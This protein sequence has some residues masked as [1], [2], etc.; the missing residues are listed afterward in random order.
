ME[1]LRYVKINIATELYSRA[2]NLRVFNTWLDNVL[3]YFG[4]YLLMGPTR[5]QTWLNTLPAALSGD[6]KLWYHTTRELQDPPLTFVNW[7]LALHVEF[8]TRRAASTAFKEYNSCEYAPEKG[9][10]AF[11]HRLITLNALLSEPHDE[12]TLSQQLLQKVPISYINYAIKFRDCTPG[13]TP[14]DTWVHELGNIEHSE[15]LAKTFTEDCEDSHS[16]RVANLPESSTAL[17]NQQT[18]TSIKLRRPIGHTLLFVANVATPKTI[19]TVTTA[20]PY[21]PA[22]ASSGTP[23]TARTCHACGQVGHFRGDPKCPAKESSGA[24]DPRLAPTGS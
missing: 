2:D 11:Y 19:H 9:I 16:K 12:P 5:E 7:I 21:K 15:L 23:S 3:L 17:V 6:A 13:I 14:I 8:I 18:S 10:L 24:G 4:T 20:A 1:H 22:I